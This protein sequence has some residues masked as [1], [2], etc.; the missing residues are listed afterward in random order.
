MRR[1]RFNCKTPPFRVDI[2]LERIEL[3]RADVVVNSNNLRL[4]GSVQNAYWKF[5]GR[6][7]VDTA[8]STAAGPQLRQYLLS[9]PLNSQG[10]RCNFGDAVLSS[11]FGLHNSYKYI[12]H[13]VSPQATYLA[14]MNIQTPEGQ[15]LVKQLRDCYHSIFRRCYEVKAASVAIPAI[16]WYV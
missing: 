7:N 15:L 6:K 1:V 4:E 13:T 16:G 8:I 14:T 12:V 2:L 11:S 5:A 9:L 10:W 3:H